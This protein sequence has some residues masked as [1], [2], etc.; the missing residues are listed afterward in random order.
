MINRN[1][2][3]LVC[4]RNDSIRLR[5]C[6]G[7]QEGLGLIPLKLAADKRQKLALGFISLIMIN[8]DP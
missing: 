5:V 2:H 4:A 1:E 8:S 7:G 3:F 6:F